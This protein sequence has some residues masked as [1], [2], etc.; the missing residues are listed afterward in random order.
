VRCESVQF[1]ESTSDEE[2]EGEIVSVGEKT[3]SSKSKGYEIGIMLETRGG[4]ET[5]PRDE[6]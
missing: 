6:S 1:A 3:E 4:T 2:K 5:S